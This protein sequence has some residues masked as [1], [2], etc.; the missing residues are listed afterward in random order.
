VRD[1]TPCWIEDAGFVDG[2]VVDKKECET[3]PIADCFVARGWGRYAYGI[4]LG[5]FRCRHEEFLPDAAVSI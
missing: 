4:G 3:V 5:D 2:E 1:Q